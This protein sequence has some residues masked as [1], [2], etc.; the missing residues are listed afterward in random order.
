MLGVVVSTLAM[1]CKWMKQLPTMLA[2]HACCS[3]TRSYCLAVCK[4][5][6]CNAHAWPQDCW[7]SCANGSNIFTLCFS[8][9]RTK[10]MLGFVA[11][12][13]WLVSNFAQQLITTCNNMQQGVQTDATCSIQQG[14]EMLANNVVFVCKGLYWSAGSKLWY[15]C[16]SDELA[17]KIMTHM[18]YWY[19]SYWSAGSKLRSLQAS[20]ILFSSVKGSFLESSNCRSAS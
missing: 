17:V 16:Y 9:H 10:E 6:T 20:R 8:D 11:S 1:V 7:K 5:T 18:D 13:G 19:L 14:W 3:I 2:H 12:K 4:E 15:L